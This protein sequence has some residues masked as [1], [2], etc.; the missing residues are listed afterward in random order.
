MKKLLPILFICALFVIGLSPLSSAQRNSGSGEPIGQPQASIGTASSGNPTTDSMAAPVKAKTI[1]VDKSQIRDGSGEDS[2]QS[3]TASP[4]A[5]V[6]PIYSRI[7]K[8]T[9]EQ[10]REQEK[11]LNEV[12]QLPVP[13]TQGEP[14]NASPANPPTEPTLGQRGLIKA[15]PNVEPEAPNDFTYRIVH[16]LTA[17]EASG[18]RSVVDEPS[19]A[20]MGNTIFFTGNWYAARST[21]AGQSFTYVSPFT[22]FPS[23]NN[24]FCCDQV[25][26]Y[27]SSQDMMLW[28]LQ[29]VSDSTSGTLRIARAVGA[30]AVANNTWI[31]YDFNPQKFGFPTNN[32]LDF[33]NL[34]ISDNYLYATAN[35]YNTVSNNF[36][37][38]VIWRIRL[39]ELAAGG[40]VNFEYLT[41]TDLGAPRCTE[42]A[43]TTMY[44]GAQPSTSQVRIYRWDD[45]SGTIFHDDVNIN[46]YL[47]LNRDGV[48]TSP[49]GT[50]W[51]ARADSRILG[52]WVANGVIGLLWPAKQGGSFPYP[53]IIIARFNQSD[54][55]LI[56]QN[57]LW[58]TQN[59]WLYPSASVNS[60]GNLSGLAAYGGGSYYPGT[61]IWISD[62]V[63]NGFNPLALYGA[64]SS[65]IGPSSNTWGDYQTI[66][67]HKD[68]P[69]TWIASAYYLKD[70]GSNVVP[71]YLWFGRERDL[72]GIAAPSAPTANAAMSVSSNSFT[73]NWSSSSGATGYRL[74]VSA[75]SAFSSY[76]SGYQDL[77]VGNVLSRSVTG[78][79]A[80]SNYYYRVR[81]YNAGG[82]SGNSNTIS[83]TT[84]SI[85]S[86]LIINAT[87]DSSITGNPNSAAIQTMINQAIAIY[88]AAYRDSVTVSILF[89]YS[90]TGPN[91]SPLSSG[92]LAQSNYVIYTTPWNSYIN[93]LNADAKTANDTTAN[94][95][96][97]A[98][99][100]S[101]NIIVGS[102]NGRAVGL[103]TPPAMFANG[104][105]ATGGP[106]DGI[107][108]LN[109]TQAFQFTRPPSGSNYDALRSTEHEIDE[110]LGLGSYL[111]GGGNLRPQDL[112]SWS[113]PGARNLT[114]SGSRYFS[115]NS[116]SNNIVGFNQ[117]SG[118]DFGDW[119]SGLSCPQTTPYVQN[120]FSC[121]GQSSDVSATSPEGINL[122]VI[123]Y[124]LV[125]AATTLSI[126]NVSPKAGRSSGGQQITLAGQF[127]GLSTVTIG[128]TVVNWSYVGGTSTI[129]FTSP[130]HAVGA[131]DIVLTPTSGNTLTKSNAFAYLPTVFTDD[132]LVA[133]VTTARVQ[134]ITELRQAV[135]ALRA[136]AGQGPAP[137]TDPL[138]MPFTD[139]IKAVHITELRTYLNNAAALLGYSTAP[140]T[141]PSLTSSFE[142]KRIHIEELRQRIRAIAG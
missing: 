29:Y 35:V 106:Y 140:Y 43:H 25:V 62:D 90:T 71:R 87:F 42:G 141:D 92:T 66:R 55:T 49:D 63:Q 83:L 96:L 132:T 67:P 14:R 47:H 84:T 65:N 138:L 50:N 23:V 122:D 26:N 28:A 4:R 46:S 52:A 134:H 18:N 128:G 39:S 61:N 37:G 119:L 59:A 135:D 117:T 13:I 72:G 54:R 86:G 130:A 36:T 139:S 124:D 126:D 99:A 1:R 60:A 64:T 82:T 85:G 21:D 5:A 100:L 91:G 78:L 137:W 69:N 34:T 118:G 9:P 101:T 110:V 103:N 104:S 22:T 15:N 31:Y 76:V 114:S 94:A 70:S 127:A 74:D 57:Q 7:P 97:P 68:N 88:Q 121:Q 108:T 105:V 53:Y 3:G 129:A 123:G 113:A 80:N 41:Q 73:A 19:T 33:P 95:S 115:I 45:F 17:G 48:A 2:A 24:G 75:N 120:A 27:A 125:S 77:D 98:S 111:P 58:S 40:T 16:D 109:S 56:S 89:R 30:A 8:L 112:F 51:A 20:N 107:V 12:N 93:A 79:S 131:V 38:S 133:G 136:V 10:L 102:A 6:G 44:W 116:G 32:W 11:E 142:I 81:A